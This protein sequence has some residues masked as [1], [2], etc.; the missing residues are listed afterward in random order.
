MAL[1]NPD[2]YKEVSVRLYRVL[3]TVG[4]GE[5]IRWKRINMFIQ[6]EDVLS[7]ASKQGQHYFGSQAEA[8]TTPGLQ[9][10]IDRVYFWERHRVIKDL[11]SWIPGIKTLLIVRDDS[12]PP[13]YVKLQN[14]YRHLPWP[15]YNNYDELLNLDRHGRF[16]LRNDQYGIKVNNCHGPANTMD[17]GYITADLVCGMRLR[18]WPDQVSQWLTRNRRHNWPSHQTIRLIQETGAL[19][20][21]VGHKFSQEQH[22][23]WRISISYGE[24]ILVW[25]FNATQYRCFILLKMINKC[26]IKPAVGNDVLSSY[27]CKT[28]LFYL[29]EHTPTAMWTPDNLLL[30]VELCLSLLYNWTESTFCPNYFIPEENM[31]QCKLYGHVKD[32]LLGVFSNLLRQNSRYLVDISCDNI[33]QNLVKMCQSPPMELQS[34][35]QHVTQSLV[36]SVIFLFMNLELAVKFGFEYDLNFET[37]QLDIYFPCHEPRREINA[38]LWK[39]HCSSIGLKL[40]SKSLSLEIPDH[41][42][43]DV[44]HEFLLWGSSSDVASGKLKLAAFYLVQDNLDMSK[45]VFNEI[46]KSYNYNVTESNILSRD[47]LQ[48]ILRENLSTTQLISQ[49]F[50]LS[51]LYH[52]SEVNC[53]PKALIPEMFCSTGSHE[54][55][56]YKQCVRIN[57][58]VYLHFLEFLCYHREHNWLHKKVA[59]DNM[60]SVIRFKDI[61]Y[62]VTALNVLAYSLTQEGRLKIVYKILCKSMKLIKE[63]NGA[64]WHLATLVNATF[65]FLRGGQ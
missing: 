12:T 2:Y 28:C 55:R 24:K 56:A 48:A 6:S 58:T 30:C 5:D 33:G 22:L 65:R 37:P 27:H 1:N 14:V 63:N 31:F 25:L 57:P 20:V 60:I 19:L 32:Q 3:D 61:Q 47:T 34:Q 23:E 39:L 11:D 64:K 16:L 26:F 52:P 36:T 18:T 13:G 59:L 9:S 53:I 43:L 41:N 51:V 21:P 38:T 42:S 15:I 4:L 46:H 62:K 54:G 50:A 35:G 10:D 29:I 8:T 7:I 45:D 40:A 49:Y 44:A 17:Y